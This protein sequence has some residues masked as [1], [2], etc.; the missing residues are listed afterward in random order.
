VAAWSA[1]SVP[2]DWAAYRDRWDAAHALSAALAAIAFVTLLAST[3]ADAAVGSTRK[4]LPEAEL[5]LAHTAR[6][7]TTEE[8]RAAR[9]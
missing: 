6:A 1:T 8:R 9:R 5:R 2:P 3:L 7:A 4:A